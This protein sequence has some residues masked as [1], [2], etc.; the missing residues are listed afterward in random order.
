M[1]AIAALVLTVIE[2][3]SQ[4]DAVR[5]VP[6][7]APTP[8]QQ[9]TIAPIAGPRLESTVGPTV[10]PTIVPAPVRATQPTLVPALEPAPPQTEQ[11]IVT[12][13]V[14]AAG[15][16]ASA[17]PTTL[18][19]AAPA[20]PTGATGARPLVDFV[21]GP[22]ARVPWPNNPASTAWLDTDGYHLAARRPGQFVALDLPEVDPQRDIRVTATFRKLSGPAGGGYGIVLRDQSAAPRDGLNQDGA[23]Y[24]AEVGDR[25]EVGMWRRNNAGWVDLVAWTPAPAVRRDGENTLVATIQ[26][27]NLTLQVNGVSVGEAADAALDAGRIGIFLGGDQNEALLTRLLVEPLIY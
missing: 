10:Q 25:G 22:A 12:P 4:G 27:N 17:A 15:A 20:I 23:F 26:G 6:T 7:E 3:T 8:N 16:P 18:P 21:A 14:I 5:P 11:P 19:T 24:V 1:L 9:P 2:N 13:A